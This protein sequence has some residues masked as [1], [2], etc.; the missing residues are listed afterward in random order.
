MTGRSLT[1]SAIKHYHTS[2]CS[3][4][5]LK[6]CSPKTH[7]K[8]APDAV[9]KNAIALQRPE[10]LGT[11]LIEDSTGT[12][13]GKTGGA[14]D[15]KKLAYVGGGFEYRQYTMGSMTLLGINLKGDAKNT[16]CK[17]YRTRSCSRNILKGCRPKMHTENTVN[18][19]PTH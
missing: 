13:A 17:H 12:P 10:R 11:D 6:G 19:Y 9:E 7:V 18:G 16:M 3:R 2:S 5:Y 1:F 8:T 4:D 15:E 14:Y